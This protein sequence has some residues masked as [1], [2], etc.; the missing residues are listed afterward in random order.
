M[1]PYFVEFRILIRDIGL[2]CLGND[3]FNNIKQNVYK[4]KR[5]NIEMKKR[6]L[7]DVVATVLI[8][9][10]ALAA[11]T[12]VWSF[13]GPSLQ[14]A[15]EQIEEQSQCSQ[16]EVELKGCTISGSNPVTRIVTGSFTT[17]LISGSAAQYK[18]V[19]ENTNRTTKVVS[20]GI[21]APQA[22]FGT[23]NQLSITMV[24][25]PLIAKWEIIKGTA[26]AVIRN[27]EGELIIC[28]PNIIEITC[29]NN[30]P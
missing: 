16:T 1:S 20:V 5:F 25:S 6:G 24:N 3:L 29:T 15:G 14:G 10:L 12:I 19:L 23:D 13:I 8:V 4:V 2:Y 9:L 18:I 30:I 7:S 22:I 11:V 27:D 17:Q 21:P 28:S 26:A